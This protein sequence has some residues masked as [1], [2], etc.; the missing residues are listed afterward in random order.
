MV[1]VLFIVIATVFGLVGLAR[2]VT[3]RADWTNVVLP[4][5]WAA[6]TVAL[7]LWHGGR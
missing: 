1:T 6:L 7:A 5:A 4:F 3:A 2:L